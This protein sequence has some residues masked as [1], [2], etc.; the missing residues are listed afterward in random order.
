MEVFNKAKAVKLRGHLNKYLVADDDQ[1]KVRQSRHGSTRGARWLVELVEGNSHVVRLKSCHGRYLTASNVPFLLGMTGHKVLQ[2]L[3]PSMKDLTIE[4]QP[5][6]DGFQ[7]KLRAFG[8]TF[9]RANGGTPPWRN[10][11][12]HDSPYYATSTQNWVLWDVEAVD[13]PENDSLKEYLSMLSTVSSLSD[14]LFGSEF[15]SPMSIHSSYSPAKSSMKNKTIGMDLFHNA[16]AVR[17]RGH[18]DKYLHAD[19]DEESVTQ[20][21]NGSSKN[22]RWTV[23]FVDRPSSDDDNINSN[24]I[25]RLKSCFGKYLTASNHP[26]LLGMTGRKV[27]QTLP[28]RLDSSVEWE[29][30]R[31]GTQ[32]KLKTRYGQF[33]RANGGLPPWRNSV[34]HDIPQRTATQDWILWDV[35]VVEIV[36]HS[37]APRPPPVL[38]SDSFASESS[39]PSNHSTEYNSFSRQEMGDSVV[40]SP[41]ISRQ[42]AKATDGRTIY[43]YV[44]DEF[45][46]VDEGVEGLCIGFKGKGVDELT[47][48]LEEETGLDDIIVCS[49]SPL[50]GKLYPL[51]LQLPPNNVTLHVVVVESSSKVAREFAKIG[52]PL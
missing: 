18:H 14:E 5:I 47:H 37:P 25:I 30:I 42:E 1:Q 20:D 48:R 10:S 44:A 9:L 21:R 27:L 2:T 3:P 13:V 45:G 12:T 39:S 40:G 43:Y 35:H 49:R 36:V 16:K 22:V 11:V 34:T 26:F 46:E 8:G 28:P 7:T 50:N 41:A 4:W 19:D 31:E 33:L 23:E 38:H 6:R 17:L 32:V 51:R 52:A 24:N 29:P 15:G